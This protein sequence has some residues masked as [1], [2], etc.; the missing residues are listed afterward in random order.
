MSMALFD[1]P[2]PKA[3]ARHKIMAVIGIAAVLAAAV[4]VVMRF[5]A[6][7]QFSTRRLDWV[8][9]KQIQL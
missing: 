1:A 6:T 7:N 2:G 8:N 4:Y 9:Y 3:R 5:I